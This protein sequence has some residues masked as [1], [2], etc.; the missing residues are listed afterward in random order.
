MIHADS[1]A[2]VMRQY[3]AREQSTGGCGQGLVRPVGEPVLVERVPAAR[4]C[5]YSEVSAREGAGRS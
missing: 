3:M 5:L 4:L 2:V 1:I